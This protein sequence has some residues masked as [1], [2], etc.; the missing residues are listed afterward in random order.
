VR[1]SAEKYGN[2]SAMIISENVCFAYAVPEDGATAPPPVLCGVD[3]AVEKGA[4]IAIVGRNGSGKSTLAKHINALLLPTG[5]TLWVNGIDT[6]DKARLW[7]IRKS[8]GMVFQNPD[9]QIV[10]TIVEEDVAFGPE[11]LGLP[12]EE[13]LRRVRAALATV[14]MTE[15][16]QSAPHHLSGGQKQRVAIA[17]VLAMR[18]SLIVLDEPTAMLDPSGRREVMETVKQLNAEAG[19]TVVLIT[20]F[21]E[22]AAQAH[23]LIVMENGRIAMEG[24]PRSIFKRGDALARLGLAVPQVVALAQAMREQGIPVAEDILEIDELIADEAVRKAAMAFSGAFFAKKTAPPREARPSAP[25]IEVRALSHMYNP[26]AAYEKK[27]ISQLSL[28]IDA[29]EIIGLIGHTGSGKSTLVQHFNALLKPTAG[30]VL[31]NAVDIHADKKQLKALRQRVGLVFQYPEH[32]LFAATVYEDVAFGPSRMGMGADELDKSVKNALA[33]VG[34]GEEVCGK[35]PFSLSGGQK[36]RV[37]IAGVLAMRPEILVLDEPT[38]GLD[39]HGR[40]E[41]LSQIHEMHERLGLTVILVSHSME[42]AARLCGRI[43][44]MNQGGIA[45]EGTPAQVFAQ[46][47]TL[48]EI[49]LAVPLVSGILSRL[50][51]INPH[52]PAGIFTVNDAALLLAGGGGTP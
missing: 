38:A 34:L 49:G 46:G 2:I 3:F 39:P 26:G 32:Q 19:I 9:N 33:S 13:I 25:L 12:S 47:K 35:S 17:G 41:I 52:I 45:M 18:P 31:I 29:G 48:E 21:M 42:D 28:A 6:K 1:A 8:A 44:V 24:T 4:F 10:A 22:E 5:G 40:E 23:R 36:R 51:E 20:H 16:A 30:Q 50:G 15:H 7:E 11:N 43:I 37:A 27:A 14:G